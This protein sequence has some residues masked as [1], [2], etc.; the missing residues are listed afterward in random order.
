MT[1]EQP[2]KAPTFRAPGSDEWL[3]FS[4]PAGVDVEVE[5][6]AREAK[7]NLKGMLLSSLQMQHLVVLV[8]SGC[9]RSAG[10]PSMDDLW[11]GAVDGEQSTAAARTAKRVHH[12]LTDK[13]IERFLSNIEAYLQVNEVKAVRK[14]LNSCKRVILDKCSGFLQDAKLDAHKTFLHRLSRRRARDQRLKIFT[15]NYD[16][17]FE[18]ATCELGGVALDGFSFAA[19]RRYDPRYFGYDIVRRPRG[20]DDLGLF[21]EG[22]FQL[23]KLHGSVNWAREGDVIYEKDSP[24][25]EEACL[26]YPASGKYHQSFLQPHL[27]SMAQYLASVRE[28]NTCLLVVGFGFTDD[29][30]AEPMLA[31]AHSNPNL[32]LVIVD[33]DAE[34]K[35]KDVNGNRYWTQLSA[36][37]MGGEDVWFINVSFEDFVQMIPD[38]K[39]LTPAETLVKAVK[40]V[41]RHT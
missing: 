15:T 31:A 41:A 29:H 14:Y 11:V 32:R 3:A 2:A 9:S 18:R 28:P 33:R 25:P 27:E 17:C 23:Y 39:S 19:P 34:N 16:L 30:L 26:I 38:L 7:E 10:G 24:T 36:L 6:K 35:V 22:V 8:G 4:A 40:G 5:K 37:G 12:E 21:L 20:G 13:N 1:Q